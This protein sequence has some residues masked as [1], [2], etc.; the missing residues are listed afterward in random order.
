MNLR[1]DIAE[2]QRSID[3]LLVQCPEL[4]E[5]ETLRAD[6][7][8]GSTEINDV[9]ARI[10]DKLNDAVWLKEAITKRIQ[11]IS[12]RKARYERQEEAL[13]GLIQSIMERADL[14]KLTLP[15]ATLSVSW[16]QPAPV[17]VDERSVPDAFCRFARTPDIGAIRREIAANGPIPPGVSMS[18]GKSVL[19][20]RT[21]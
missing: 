12:A 17:V 21:K 5:D 19:S 10:L 13:R 16:R 3:T 1:L 4:A 8:E 14:N 11:E 6:M 7:I 2:L 9:L 15:E 18:N 20:I